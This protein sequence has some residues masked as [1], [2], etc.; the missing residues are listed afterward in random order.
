MFLRSEKCPRCT[1]TYVLNK[2]DKN[3]SLHRCLDTTDPCRQYSW[4]ARTIKTFKRVFSLHSHN[5]NFWKLRDWQPPFNFRDPAPWSPGMDLRT[6][7]S[8]GVPS[9]HFCGRQQSL[10]EKVCARV[11]LLTLGY[12]CK[13]PAETWNA[14]DA[15]Y[16]IQKK[17]C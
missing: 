4:L 9:P 8:W 10:W 14:V 13:E 1:K 2:L 6:C 16:L 5:K 7:I 12:L 3:S 15:R 11:M 17:C